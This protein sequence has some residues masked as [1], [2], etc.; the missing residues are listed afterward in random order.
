VGALLG[1]I[2]A[3]R[4]DRLGAGGLDLHNGLI[5]VVCFVRDLFFRVAVGDQRRALGDIM[6]L[7]WRQNDLDWF[8][9]AVARYGNFRTEAATRSAQRFRCGR[10]AFGASRV[11]MRPN[12][13]GIQQQNLEIRILQFVHDG[14]EHS[15]LAPAIEALKHAVPFAEAL[16]QITPGSAG[17]GDPPNGIHEQAIV[18]GRRAGVTFL[19]RQEVANRFPLFVRNRMAWQHGKLVSDRVRR[20][21]PPPWWPHPIV[22]RRENERAQRPHFEYKKLTEARRT[23]T[24]RKT[25]KTYG[26]DCDSSSLRQTT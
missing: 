3:R 24:V 13:R 11:L 5:A 19:P 26:T 18:L 22:R 12:N 15:R 8:P 2:A 4:N 10:A 9:Q 25:A 16:G 23:S 1:A 21:L 17:L 6:I 7:S 20:V 14:L